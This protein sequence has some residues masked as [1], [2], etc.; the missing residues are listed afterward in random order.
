MYKWY[1]YTFVKSIKLLGVVIDEYL[2]F[3]NHV[4]YAIAKTQRIFKNLCKY[5]RPT[6]GIHA[7]NVVVIYRQVVEPMITYAAG[8]WGSATNYYYIRR[9]L[10]SFQRSFAIK[11]IRA[12][13]TV[14]ATSALA[15]S[16]FA[17]LHLKVAE[18]SKIYEVKRTGSLNKIPTEVTLQKSIRP[19]RLLHPGQ[20]QTIDY[21]MVNQQ[22]QIDS[23]TTDDT[24]QIFT[25]GSKLETDECGSAFVVFQP[26]GIQYKQRLK[27][28]NVCTV[29]QAEAFAIDSALAW[30]QMH[31]ATHNLHILSDS[32]SCL[33]AIKIEVTRLR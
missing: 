33:Q 10:R 30:S 32:Q 25:D 26:N 4:R 11:A 23:S 31:L 9:L 28:H 18:A 20:R 8:V 16:G 6:W 3:T 1:C 22:A 27:L 29:F 7:E 21:S 17:P 14:S 2:M 5:V 12:F 13:H 15:L 19:H 24:T